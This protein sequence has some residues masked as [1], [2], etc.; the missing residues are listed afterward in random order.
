VSVDVI[1]PLPVDQIQVDD[2]GEDGD[3]GEVG[4]D[5]AGGQLWSSSWR[6]SSLHSSGQLLTG[7]MPDIC[8]FPG[9]LLGDLVGVVGCFPGQDREQVGSSPGGV[10]HPCWN[11]HLGWLLV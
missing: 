5:R 8:K 1:D 7:I 3:D 11:T 6:H 9:G 10:D 4:D 2:G